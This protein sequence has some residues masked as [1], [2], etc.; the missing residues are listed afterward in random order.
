[1]VNRE[2]ASV[3]HLAGVCVARGFSLQQQ[4]TSGSVQRE[5][6]ASCCPDWLEGF[7]HSLEPSSATFSTEGTVPGLRAVLL[8]V[9][10]SLCQ[11]F[12]DRLNESTGL[13][14]S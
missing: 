3:R 4:L 6:I 12:P 10:H 1:M 2:V 14:D 11:L 7:A 8:N 9:A 5:L 13:S